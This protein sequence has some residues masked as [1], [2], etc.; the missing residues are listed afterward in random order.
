MM[1][2]NKRELLQLQLCQQEILK[3]DIAIK[4]QIEN[5]KRLENATHKQVSDL[6]GEVKKQ[7]VELSV[8]IDA[9]ER[10]SNKVK[11]NKEREELLAQ[12]KEHRNELDRNRHSLRHVVLS[13]MKRIEERS[14]DYLFR[15]NELEDRDIELRHRIKRTE[16]LKKGSYKATE[17]LSSL[18]SR[19]SEQV[20][21][22]E[23]ST[24]TLIH[25]SALLS[26]TEGEF[27]SMSAHIQSGG[28][29]ISKYGR[30]ECTDKILIALALLLYFLV[31]FYIL[32]KRVFYF[33][34]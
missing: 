17:S 10:L 20:K 18:V 16:N 19:M 24:S 4:N 32:R 23:E 6:S 3:S 11:S 25:S 34:Y 33:I 5:I 15:R 2:L 29:L 9:L 30:R 31:I 13:Q 28:K 27:A 21:L 1:D 8:Q 14:K 26:E 22:S 7:F 12:T